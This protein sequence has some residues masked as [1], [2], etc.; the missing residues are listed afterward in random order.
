MRKLLL[1]ALIPVGLAAGAVLPGQAFA[2][3][4]PHEQHA[5]MS[6]NIQRA[7]YYYNHHHYHHRDWDRDHHHWHYYD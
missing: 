2:A 7:D 5:V 3:L 4:N 6:S 1:S